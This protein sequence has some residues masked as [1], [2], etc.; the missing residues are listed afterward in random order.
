MQNTKSKYFNFILKNCIS[1]C[2]IFS[3]SFIVNNIESIARSKKS[4]K[5]NATSKKKTYKKKTYKKKTS[6]KTKTK[7]SFAKKGIVNFTIDTVNLIDYNDLKYYNLKF[8]RGKI[9]HSSH[10]IEINKTK[11]KDIEVI[12]AGN[13]VRDLRRLHSL[14]GIEDSSDNQTDYF[15]GINTSFWRAYSNTPIGP[16]F[17]NGEPIELKSY[18]GW[19]STFFDNQNTPYIGFF[20]ID[21]TVKCDNLCEFTINN[22]NKRSDS[23]GVILYNSYYGDEIPYIAEQKIEKLLEETLSSFSDA[24]ELQDSTEESFDIEQFRQTQKEIEQD[25]NIENDLIKLTCEYLDNPLINKDIKVRVISKNRGVVSIPENGFVISFGKDYPEDLVPRIGEMILLKYQTNIYS[26]ILFKSSV[27]ATPRLVTE[28]IAKHQA[29]EEGSKGRRFISKDLP[30]T[31]IGYNE[32][33]SKI[34]LVCVEATNDLGNRGVTL[35]RLASL[36]KL[37]GCYDAMNLDGGGSSNMIVESKN[38]ARKSSMFNSR[39]IS[40]AI[41]VK[42]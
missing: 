20:N 39:K 40:V 25:K 3:F 28:G 42:K 1:L 11:F 32:D 21:A 30:R 15:G 26:D 19:S 18:K 24:L 33:K 29:Y 31:A 4:T 27:S 41:G 34:Y 2:L 36:M 22:I 37:I 9:H 35:E 38:R 14:L 16:T 23:S 7:S 6:K 13:S 10:I 12:K 8:N 5:K 17:I